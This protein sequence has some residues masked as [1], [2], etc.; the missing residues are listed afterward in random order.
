MDWGYVAEDADAYQDLPASVE[1]VV[2]EDIVL[3][4]R[5]STDPWS[6][7]A[8]R[9]RFTE[10]GA[11]ASVAAV[12][13]W[14]GGRAVHEFRWLI[15]ASATPMTVVDVLLELGAERDEEEPELTAM[16]LDREPP[17][18]TDV[19]VREIT[20]LADFVEMDRIRAEVFGGGIR[21]DS[22]EKLEMRWSE[23]EAMPGARAFLAELDGEAVA[24]GVMR[25]TSEGPVLLGGGVTLPHA[26]GHGAYR[27]LV[28]ARWDA[29]RAVGAPVLVTQAQAAS[30]PIL[31]RLGFRTT[32][33]IAVLVDRPTNR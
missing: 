32:A 13:Q 6:N 24:Y 26:R 4:H 9:V 12:R 14:F 5:P 23:F 16:V 17:P 25:R 8:A 28:R 20:S 21:T 27:A 18:V 11:S 33:A 15:G 2:R 31:E 7:L 10:N 1:R 30:R 19:D 29:A 22:S 3:V